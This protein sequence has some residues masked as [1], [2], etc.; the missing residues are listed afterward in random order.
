MEREEIF[1]KSISREINTDGFS[2]IENASK[3]ASNGPSGYSLCSLFA[4]RSEPSSGKD[5]SKCV[6]SSSTNQ[7]TISSLN[8]FLRLKTYLNSNSDVI[9]IT[10]FSF[11]CSTYFTIL[12]GVSQRPFSF[13]SQFNN[14]S[15]SMTTRTNFSSLDFSI[16]CFSHLAN[17]SGAAYT[18]L[19]NSRKFTE[20][21]CGKV[22]SFWAD[23]LSFFN[24]LGYLLKRSHNITSTEIITQIK[25]F[26]KLFFAKLRRENRRKSGR[27]SFFSHFFSTKNFLFHRN[28]KHFLT[29]PVQDYPGELLRR[30]PFGRG[31]FLYL[32]ICVL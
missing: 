24:G 12:N 16:K 20:I 5:M 25:D 7:F 8:I 4:K 21:S 29:Q 30:N 14:T 2:E 10:P 15:V 17:I 23:F 9:Q 22:F 11:P 27:P 3:I 31:F 18:V 28:Y 6:L 13:V 26:V 19:Y 32:T 1:N